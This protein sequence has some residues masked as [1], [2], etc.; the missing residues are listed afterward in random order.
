MS[1]ISIYTGPC[2]VR[3]IANACRAAGFQGVTEGTEHVYVRWAY[4]RPGQWYFQRCEATL[5]KL[6]RSA[7]TTF[8]LTVNDVTFTHAA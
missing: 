3:A 5:R 1:R 8:G 6:Q 7:G 2:N 4:P